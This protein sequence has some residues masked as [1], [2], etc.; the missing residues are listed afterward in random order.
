MSAG[1][2]YLRY[3]IEILTRTLVKIE[4]VPDWQILLC[5]TLNAKHYH[6]DATFLSI[7]QSSK[8]KKTALH[9]KII[10]S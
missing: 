5:I 1:F 9:L 7:I 10:Q 2:R 6:N 8:M 4:E 3:P